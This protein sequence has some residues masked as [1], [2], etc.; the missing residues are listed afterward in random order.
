MTTSSCALEHADE[1][2]P[3]LEHLVDAREPRS[4]CEVGRVGVDHL[5]VHLRRAR[6]VAQARLVELRDA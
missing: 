2:G 5:A 6:R 4:A 1:L 3:L